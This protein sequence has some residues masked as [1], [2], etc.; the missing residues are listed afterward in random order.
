VPTDNT[1]DLHVL[2]QVCRQG[3]T[4]E[5][6]SDDVPR[7]ND[8]WRGILAAADRHGLIGPVQAFAS[9]S[10]TVPDT[11]L[12][13]LR[14]AFLT[15]SARNFGLMEAL[16]EILRAFATA[17]IEVAVWKGPAVALLAYERVAMREFTD[18]DLLVRPEDLN[19]GRVV[20]GN[21]GYRQNGES[22]SNR[23]AEKDI[24]FKRDADEVVVELH[25]ALNASNRRFPIEATGIWERL[26][27]V[28]F[29][30]Q[31]IRTLGLEDTLIGLCV[32]GSVHRWTSL[33]WV[34]DVAWIVRFK[35]ATLDWDTLIERC[36]AA[37]C[38]R[39]LLVSLRVASLLFG[40]R[41]PE[42]IER[43]MSNNPTVMNL[44]EKI[45]HSL[46]SNQPLSQSDLTAS[47]IQ[48]HDR[49]WDRFFVAVTGPAPEI[50]S[51]LPAMGR[52]TSGPLRFISRPVRLAYL[53]GVPWLRNVVAGR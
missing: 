12:E 10:N 13:S 16:I 19:R 42:V 43:Q 23:R 17:S 18:L 34:F 26:Q 7:E 48:I 41:M 20:L 4:D 27:T 39:T 47:N 49:V 52:V 21:L 50:P 1:A 44:A 30:N 15:Q 5:A 11:V 31:P 3:L 53:Y 36:T 22:D 46:K 28:Y 45:G 37:G 6:P 8:G 2:V 32:H 9:Q 51:L 24:Q 25:W 40:V 35:A 14:I 29:Q 38:S 33:K